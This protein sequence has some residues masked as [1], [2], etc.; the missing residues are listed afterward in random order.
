MQTA[1]FFF[2]NSAQPSMHRGDRAAVKIRETGRTPGVN[3]VC[4]LLS[5]P[6]ARTL[7]SVGTVRARRHSQ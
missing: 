6:M 3:P 4:S 2:T 7:P 1:G 5:T